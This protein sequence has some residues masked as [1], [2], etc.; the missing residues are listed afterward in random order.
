MD[1]II[2]GSTRKNAGKTGMIIG[3][4]Q[5]NGRPFG[6][7]KPL[8]DRMFY[9]KKRLWD[10]DSA[11]MVNIFNLDRDPED[12]SIGFDHAKIRY[13]YNEETI[14]DRLSNLVTS[15]GGGD[16]IVYVESGQDLTCG[17]SVNLDALSVAR[18]T[19]G[20]LVIV[21]SGDDDVIMDDLTFMTRHIDYSSVDFRGVIVNKVK[22]PDEFR[23]TYYDSIERMGIGVIGLVPHKKELSHMSVS[24][25]VERL[26]VKVLA[27]EE[28]LGNV[29]QNIFIAAE[30][31]KGADMDP[32]FKRKN[33][34]IITS[35]DRSDII[36]AALESDT[37]CVLLANNVIPSP[38][39]I[40][41]A[42]EMNIP[43]LLAPDDIYQ[44]IRQVDSMD[45]VV[46]QNERNK[47]E[48]LKR[49][50]AEHL[51]MEKI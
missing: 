28:G 2:I 29:I 46:A 23:Y 37:A 3:L 10:Y 51:D 4:A 49:L 15:S 14:K 32:H 25:L 1:R 41:K 7:V 5:A 11:L 21:V 48:M 38:A 35:G 27:G 36:V 20:K 18:Y 39:I 44:V 22:D 17:A 43:L 45:I 8:G 6:Y 31:H 30:S 33:K 13:M 50:V 24:T 9:R 26:F 34:L 16:S 40:S 12:L 19:E 47:I 42:S